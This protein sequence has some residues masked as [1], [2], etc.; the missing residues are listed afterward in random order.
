MKILTDLLFYVRLIVGQGI[1]FFNVLLGSI[2]RKKRVRIYSSPQLLKPEVY[3]SDL[4]VEL[5]NDLARIL[6][7]KLWIV[8][9]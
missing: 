7:N 4:D 3:K 8:L 2:V 1:S 5:F 6:K 9:W